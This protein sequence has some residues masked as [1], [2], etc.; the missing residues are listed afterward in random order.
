MFSAF[1]IFVI[2]KLETAKGNQMNEIIT[3]FR[4]TEVSVE[5]RISLIEKLGHAFD[6]QMGM[7]ISDGVVQELTDL[8][9]LGEVK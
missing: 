4:M 2:Y 6:Y 5:T 9:K 3:V 7:K 8:L 1:V